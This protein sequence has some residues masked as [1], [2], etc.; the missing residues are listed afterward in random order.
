M[1]KRKARDDDAAAPET[2]SKRTRK[3]T[4]LDRDHSPVVVIPNKA[5]QSTSKSTTASTGHKVQEDERSGS[6]TPKPN[7][8]ST[9]Q[10][11]NGSGI[12]TPSKTRNADRSAKRKSARILAEAEREDDWD[13]EGA[14]AAAILEDED[15]DDADADPDEEHDREEDEGEPSAAT[16]T[17]GRRKRAQRTRE[18]R[19][20]TPEG[21]IEPEERY[22]FQNRAGPPQYSTNLFSSVKLLT[23]EE[24]FDQM[25]NME[26]GHH[27]EKSYL[28][29]L[30]ARSFPQ[31]KFELSQGYSICLY[32]YG[33]KR[34]MVT[35]FAEWLHTH[36]K[37]SPIIVVVNGFTPKLNIKHILNTV[38]SAIAGSGNNVKL[39]GQ[40]QQML[41]TLLNVMNDYG[42]TKRLVILINSIDA[43]ALRKGSVQSALSRLAAHPSV[44]LLATADTPTFPL[45]WSSTLLDQFSFVFHDCTTLARYESELSV[46]D[47]VY[48]LLGRKGRRLGGREG[49]GYVLQS[50][51]PNA[52]KLYQ[53]L[54]TEILTILEEGLDVTE[55][56]VE[57]EEGTLSK[58]SHGSTTDVGVEYRLLYQ[59]A[60]EDFVCSSDM[61]F[62]FLLK[63]FHDHQ[64]ITSRRDA[65]GT[66]LLC[67]PLGKEEMQAVLEDLVVA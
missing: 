22:F 57:G 48:D 15:E 26:D 62:R 21:D 44:N 9:P 66:E 61:N 4:R 27:L 14:L 40:P 50:L 28:A 60:A 30:H 47:E 63:E 54:L 7:G 52:R 8:F 34:K 45:M 3:S 37:R 16:P 11:L 64:M 43:L 56:P 53:I 39:T 35:R 49:V 18:Q 19:S 38:G 17:R 23:H 25:R 10:K 5:Q 55:H 12:S 32:G 2:P 13:G 42:Q 51:P 58:P 1:S 59:K 65:S 36:S 29:K 6:P 41:D 20:P 24:Y 33:S 67:V 31:W 46:V